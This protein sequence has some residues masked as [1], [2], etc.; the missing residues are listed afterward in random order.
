[1]GAPLFYVVSVSGQNDIG[2]S[3]NGS[4]IAISNVIVVG[5]PEINKRYSFYLDQRGSNIPVW[6]TATYSGNFGGSLNFAGR[7]PLS[8]KSAYVKGSTIDFY[9]PENPP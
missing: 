1:M 4:N 9:P 2:V 8:L 7:D 6:C 3:V 5:T